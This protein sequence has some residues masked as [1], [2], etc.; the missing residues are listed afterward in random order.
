MSGRGAFYSF[1]FD[2]GPDLDYVRLA[3]QLLKKDMATV[4]GSPSR[5]GLR[6]GR[7]TSQMLK[8]HRAAERSANF[9]DTLYSHPSWKG[10][11]NASW[12]DTVKVSFKSPRIICAIPP[13]SGF[14][15]KFRTLRQEFD[16]EDVEHRVQEILNNV[17][18]MT[19]N[20]QLIADAFMHQ[21][22][23]GAIRLRLAQQIYFPRYYLKTEPFIRLEMNRVYFT[24]E[25]YDDE[26][27]EISLMIHRSGVCIMTFATPIASE[28][29]VNRGH[30]V[31]L[32][33]ARQF[34]RIMVSEPILS[35]QGAYTSGIRATFRPE[36]DI[37]EGLRWIVLDS[38]ANQSHYLSIESVFF[39][40]LDAIENIVGKEILG[41]W[42]CNTTLFQGTPRCGCD[43]A[44]SKERHAVEFG[45]LMVRSRSPFPVK[46]EVRQELLTNHLITTHAELWLTA[47][48]AI[49]TYWHRA[50][51][52]YVDDLHTVEAI[53]FAIL[54]Y[55]Q[56]EAIDTRT[57]NIAVH[58]R[59]LAA[60]QS[61]L[62]TNLPEYGR[63]LL[64]DQSAALVVDG[65]AEKLKTPQ[66][67]SRLNDRVKVLE[68]IVN[69]RYTR[70][71]SRRS[72]SISA[73]GLA[74]VV[75]L[76]LPRVME[77]TDRLAKLSPTGSLIQ[78]IAQIFG[79]H[80]RAVIGIYLIMVA[81]IALL[82]IIL[83]V[84]RPTVGKRWH[85]PNFGYDTEHDIVL[86]REPATTEE[87]LDTSDGDNSAT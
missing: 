24:D 63:N 38:T 10:L 69:T 44:E 72:L 15:S 6:I 43:G 41:E 62:A 52:D 40:Y 5:D 45:Q 3:D 29:D 79:S 20:V 85:N 17:N 21:L 83:T 22:T 82:F 67:Y 61:Q 59:D 86:V 13:T 70:K 18:I 71:Q 4:A 32:G 58:D 9:F 39:P 7:R 73:I 37:H 23:L 57:V 35:R 25:V 1:S 14:L 53:E 78:S 77:L 56:L 36:S 65:L 84:K 68:S 54:Q 11:W 60:A 12:K 74:I 16:S 28:F 46:E 30:D 19:E 50:D 31:M 55:R 34:T 2:L 76:L 64:T 27:I 81:L 66:L 51:I 80:D 42:R 87:T 26:P 75:L 33:S 48:N 8:F 47:G 49:H